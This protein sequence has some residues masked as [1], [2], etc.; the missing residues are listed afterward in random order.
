MDSTKHQTSP[1]QPKPSEP[2]Q[3][4]EELDILGLL[5]EEES[6]PEGPLATETTLNDLFNRNPLELDDSDIDFICRKMKKAYAT[7]KEEEGKA[8]ATGRRAKH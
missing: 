4:K 7:F 2:T 8:K 3:T 5:M 1:S 6:V